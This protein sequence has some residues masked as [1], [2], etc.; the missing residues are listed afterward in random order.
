[1]PSELLFLSTF[2]MPGNCGKNDGDIAL[3][4][5]VRQDY[6]VLSFRRILSSKLRRNV[7]FVSKS[8]YPIMSFV[9]SIQ[10]TKNSRL[11]QETPKKFS[12]FCSDISQN[13]PTQTRHFR[14]TQ[15]LLIIAAQIQQK[16]KKLDVISPIVRVVVG[17][18]VSTSLK[19]SHFRVRLIFFLCYRA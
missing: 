1:M 4:G 11:F 7:V 5:E 14:H 13:P 15:V 8:F 19:L 2:K 18:I 16:F 9:D 10:A 17:E 12:F 6:G 3:C